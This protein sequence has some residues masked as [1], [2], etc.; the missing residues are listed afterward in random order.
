MVRIFSKKAF[1]LGP[2]AQKD[3]TV[4]MIVTVVNGFMDIPEKYT[5]CRMFELAVQEGSI[6]VI[7]NKQHQQQVEANAHKTP[8]VEEHEDFA[9]EV[10]GMKKTEVIAKAKE[11][12]VMFDETEKLSDIRRKVVE[13]YKMQ[14]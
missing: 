8:V 9:E 11:L 3:G 13:A 4:D 1:G 12:G 2:G 5:H 6:T 10:K 14:K 7:E